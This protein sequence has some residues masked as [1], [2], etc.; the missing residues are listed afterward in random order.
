MQGSDALEDTAVGWDPS[1]ILQNTAAGQ[2]LWRLQR[3]VAYFQG[4]ASVPRSQILGVE[5]LRRRGTSPCR[6]PSTSSWMPATRRTWFTARVYVFVSVVG[7]RWGRRGVGFLAASRALKLGSRAV[8]SLE[9]RKGRRLRRV[10]CPTARA[11][12]DKSKKSSGGAVLR[13]FSRTCICIWCGGL[14]KGIE[15]TRR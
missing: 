5:D 14:P 12:P 15:K 6:N 2:N 13:N 9:K 4:P 1:A 11:L 7:G 8:R 3:E 10:T